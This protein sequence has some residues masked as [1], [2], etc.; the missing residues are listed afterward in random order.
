MGRLFSG[1]WR[2]RG[3]IGAALAAL[4]LLPGCSALRLGYG[5]LPTLSFWWIDGYVGFD[6]AQTRRVREELRRWVEWHQQTQLG[7]YA[8]FLARVRGEATLPVTGAQVCRLNDAMRELL[9]PAIERALPAAA[10]I[11]ATLTPQ[12]LDK[13]DARYRERTDEMRE[14]M[15]Q[16][17]LQE[18]RKAAVQRAVKRFE[19]FYG[20]LDDEQRRLVDEG[21]TASPFDAQDW[22]GQRDRRHREMLETLAAIARE[23]P[24]AL[25]AQERLR[26]LVRRF[27]GRAPV[28]SP[29]Q[30]AA[31]AAYNCEL[32]ARL[33]NTTTP[34]QRRHLTD[35]LAGW[36]SDLRALA[37]QVTM[38]GP[39]DA[40]FT[41]RP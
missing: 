6:G 14:D 15:L 22:F 17:D 9:D 20:R 24:A 19:T 30:A 12:Q 10:A 21:L 35:K 23:G 32:T 8:A 36:E 28:G 26:V 33:H 2:G 11:V 5:Q 34:A 16:R 38:P 27:D 25:P 1:V 39:R 13:I 31:L 3:I 4:L 29:Q 7:T 40:A 37:A 18:R 41:A